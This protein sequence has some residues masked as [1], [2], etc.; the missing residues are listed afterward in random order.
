YLRAHSEELSLNT[1]KIVIWGN[2]AGGHL[3]ALAA[4]HDVPAE[5]ED[6]SMGNADCSSQVDGLLAW[7]GVYDL[8]TQRPQT[9]ELFP[10]RDPAENDAS[11]SML[12]EDTPARRE[13]ASP[14]TYVTADYPPTLLQQGTGDVLVPYLQAVEFHDRLSAICGPDRVQ[15]DLFPGAGHGAAEIKA[16]ANLLR[17]LRF[18]DS[19]Y[20]PDSS[21]P[22]PRR[23][24]PELRYVTS[25]C[26][27]IDPYEGV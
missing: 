7:Y 22:Y 4:A 12:G 13:A 27:K 11:V 1:E 21:C 5:L 19:V 26:A 20:Y 23:P 25:T 18:L 14:I 16:D 17:C 15:L 24:L 2:S 8:N 9:K 3:A 10:E 6:L